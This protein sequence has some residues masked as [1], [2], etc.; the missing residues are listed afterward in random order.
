VLI[1]YGIDPHAISFELKEDGLQHASVDCGVRV[2]NKAGADVHTNGNTFSAALTADQYQK[3]IRT[4]YP[5]NQSLELPPGDYFLRLA[6]RDD[7]SG[8]IGTANAQVSI[9]A[10]TAEKSAQQEQKKP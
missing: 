6:V 3:V 2:Y 7:S 8:L 9:P 1:R 4:I 10:T 5:C